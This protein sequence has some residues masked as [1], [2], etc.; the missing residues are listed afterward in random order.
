MVARNRKTDTSDVGPENAFNL[1]EESTKY[2]FHILIVKEFI[3]FL[4]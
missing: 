1:K 3:L 4:F 2:K